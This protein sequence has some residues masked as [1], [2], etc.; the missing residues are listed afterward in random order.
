MIWLI[1]SAMLLVWWIACGVLAYGWLF[2]Y[3]QCEWPLAAI[4]DYTS[5]RRFA[6]KIGVLGPAGLLA[7]LLMGGWRHGLKWR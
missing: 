3:Q 4:E 1:I 5:D 2:A 6:F 7:T